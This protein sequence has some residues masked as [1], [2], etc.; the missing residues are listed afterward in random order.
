MLK[1]LF[2][3]VMLATA[4]LLHGQINHSNK[5]DLLIAQDLKSKK[6]EMP[7]KSSDDVFVRRAFLDIV[8]RIPTYEESY[9]F[10]KYNDRDA[11][12][13]YL[14]STQGYNESMFN[15]YADILRLQKR[16]G[17]RTSAETYI[18]WVREQIKKNVPYNKIVKDILTA[19]GTIFTNPA[20]GYFLRD[21]GM[22]L[23]NVSNTFQGFAGMD[24]S[25]AQCHDHPFDDWSQM[26]YYEMSAF[27]TTVD[28]R[29]TDK[30]ESKHY[31]KLREEA[32][33]SDTAKTTKR[34]AND[35]RNYYQQGYRNK[36][37]SNLKKT[38]ALPHDYKYKDGAPGEIITAVTPVGSR[39]KENRKRKDLEVTF[40]DWLIDDEHPTFAANIVNR[41]W[42]KAFGFG[43][44]S[45]LN[46]IAEYDE[47][48]KSRNDRLLLYLVDVMKEVNYDVKKFN[49]ILYK[50]K[51][52]GCETD[53]VDNFQGPIMRRM[54]AAQLWDSLMTL[55]TGNVD[56]WQPENRIEELQGMFPKMTT[57]TLK[58]ALKGYKEY[59][60]YKKGYYKG[61]P[62]VGRYTAIRSSMIFD[63]NARNFLLEFGASDRELIENGNQEANIMQILTLMNSSMTKE[64]MSVKGRIGQKL[65]DYKRDEAIDYVFRS[66]IGRSP[67]AE[68]LKAFKGVSY[69][70]IVW[71]LVNSHEFKLIF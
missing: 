13:D 31:N 69:T 57:L 25:C 71:V 56:A 47:L 55:Y 23:D 37:D 62:K 26:E 48:K 50:T 3:S 65:V 27:F 22:L 1:K 20:V 54:T 8:G 14:I 61:A 64:L 12:V 21:E 35:I 32:R 4:T 28:T 10:K 18:T 34:A 58:Q 38:L 5:I 59:E 46:S 45:E 39:V 68:E 7:K 29:A 16:L 30:A 9:E 53:P 52:Y 66:F 70:D 15:F 44:I 42:H 63:G 33:A 43:L 19:Q 51:F 40:A 41:L 67:S 2:Y 49:T 11:L 36:V 60:E 24:V 17:G 6:L